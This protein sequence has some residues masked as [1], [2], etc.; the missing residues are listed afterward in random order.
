MRKLQEPQKLMG[1]GQGQR[2]QGPAQ[3]CVKEPLES[4]TNN[5]S[6]QGMVGQFGW[7]FAC[8]DM[9]EGAGT[10]PA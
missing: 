2:Q 3:R 8:N 9:Q 1:H 10:L 7:E 4:T 6:K 5:A